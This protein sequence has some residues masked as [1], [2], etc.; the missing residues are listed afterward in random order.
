MTARSLTGSHIS[1]SAALPATYD[2]AGYGALTFTKDDCSLSAVPAI[3]RSFSGVTVDT[4][5]TANNV[6]KK[7]KATYDPVSFSMVSDP[8]NT[9]QSMLSTAEAS[10]T[11][12]ISVKIEF[13]LGS[14]TTAETM[15]FTTQVAKFSETDG[16][17]GDTID[18]RSCEMWIQSQE[19]V[20]VAAT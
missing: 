5:C 19:I 15:Y 20:R 2:A 8:A 12:V 16:G 10:V 1:V 13:P 18:M 3:S 11:D 14:N 6:T 4:V 17:S 7:G 9:V